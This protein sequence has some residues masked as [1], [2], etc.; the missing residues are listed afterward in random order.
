MRTSR[1]LGLVVLVAC[2]AKHTGDG[3]DAPGGDALGGEP[4]TGDAT[5]CVDSTFQKCVDGVFQTSATCSNA[6]VPSL[7]GCVDCD[8]SAGS[9]ACSGSDIVACNPD[10]SFGVTEMSCGNGQA[11]M[12]GSC[13]DVCTADGVDLVY[14]VDEQNDFMSFDPRKLP[15]NP[16][17]KIG[18]LTCPTQDPTI[19]VPP[20]AVV[21]QSMG[22]DRNGV[23]WVEYT[24][25]EIFN[26]SLTDATCTPSGYVPRAGGMDLFGMGFV[27]DSAGSNSEK[28]FIAG[29]GDSA[30]PMGK[31]ATVDTHDAM[32]TPVQIGTLTE[33]SD[34]SPELTGTNA[35]ELFGFFPV[36]AT[37]AYVQQIDRTTGAA[38][39]SAYN[40]GTTGLGNGIRDWAF[41][42]WG[43][44]FYIFVTTTDSGGATNSTVRSIDRATGTY[45]VILQN[46]T[47]NVDGAGVSTCAP[48]VIN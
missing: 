1:L 4:C 36:L 25:G 21:P 3:P 48:S 44:V 38:M 15:G 40:L 14:V 8:P 27:T 41:A 28:L 45:T 11:C 30:Q 18:T 33:S 42:Q 23:A 46:L 34:F 22:V 29:G 5:Q 17:T 6:C 20:G 24:S 37:P 12:A 13:S 9:S 31:L 19:Q 26:V 7:G 10:G 32:Y 35:A 43:G 16:F 39:G 47:F 2:G